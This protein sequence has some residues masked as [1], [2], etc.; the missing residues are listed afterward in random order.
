MAMVRT[1]DRMRRIFASAYGIGSTAVMASSPSAAEPRRWRPRTEDAE[2]LT[3]LLDRRQN[4]ATALRADEG[5]EFGRRDVLCRA[6]V[7][8]AARG[9]AR[10]VDHREAHRDGGVFAPLLGPGLRQVALQQVH[11]GHLVPHAAAGL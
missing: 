2:R 3:R 10:H 9:V 5:P 11:V 1:V 8:D 6:A 4:P 7:D